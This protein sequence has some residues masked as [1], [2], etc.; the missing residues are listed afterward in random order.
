MRRLLR[1]QRGIASVQFLIYASLISFMIFGTID[2]WIT[3]QRV[4]QVEFIK[5]YY[6][7]RVRLEGCLTINDEASL[8]SR[9]IA[10]QFSNIVIDTIAKESLGQSRVLRN[11]S[12]LNGSE[13]Y[14]EIQC[15]P[16]PQPFLVAQMIGTGAPGPFI[17]DVKGRALSERVDP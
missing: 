5:N 11:T 12:D 7:D 3:Q 14:L 9:L 8:T 1:D 15:E 17:I 6:L 16:T 10:A 2:Y 4:S 13:V